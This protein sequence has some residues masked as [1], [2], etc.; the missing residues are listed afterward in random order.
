MHIVFPATEYR[1]DASFQIAM[2]DWEGSPDRGWNVTR[3]GGPHLELGPGYRPL[4]VI[5]CGICSTDLAR[6]YLPFPLPQVIGHVVEINASHAARGLETDCPFCR[7]G[8]TTHCPDRFTLGIDRLPG[9]FGPHILAP[10]HA[11]IPVPAAIPD[12]SAVVVEP[13]AAALHAVTTVEPRDGERVAVLG[14]RRLGLLVV[15]ALAAYR[16]SRGRTYR[17]LALARRP[18]LIE[19]AR[20]F[21]ADTG[22]LV[23]DSGEG[24]PTDLADV[25]IDTTGNP[26]ALSLALDL[27]RREVHVK[28]THG[29]PSAGLHHLTELVVDELR[30]ARFDARADF[31]A[32]VVA[33]LASDSPP[34]GFEARRLLAGE[35]A[36]VLTRMEEEAPGPGGLPRADVAVVDDLAGVDRAIR[37]RHDREVSL[38]RPQGTILIRPD[39]RHRVASPLLDAVLGRNLVVSSSRCGDFHTALDLMASDPGLVRVGERLVTHRFRVSALAEAFRIAASDACVKAVVDQEDAS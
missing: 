35:P 19:R 5:S 32:Q 27:A 29:R 14:P 22:L 34:A 39:A 24:L 38:V 36:A 9:G 28:S 25:V 15:A 37:P 33:W 2:Y 10:I 23:G 20:T 12:L 21:G 6:R 31:R 13:L 11:V 7:A 26:E 17:I 16:V 18:E 1:A 4:R 3:E 8:L 30:I